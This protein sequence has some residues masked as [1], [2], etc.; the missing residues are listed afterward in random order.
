MRG[1]TVKGVCVPQRHK[2]VR[3]AKRGSHHK[4][5]EALVLFREESSI[6]AAGRDLMLKRNLK[7]HGQNKI[8]PGFEFRILPGGG[9]IPRDRQRGF[10]R[11][12]G[13]AKD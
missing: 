12:E 5:P 4:T 11:Y 6:T 13:L 7:S 3:E 9:E 1:C 8:S 2:N 10:C